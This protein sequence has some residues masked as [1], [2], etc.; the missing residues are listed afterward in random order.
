MSKMKS[1]RSIVIAGLCGLALALPAVRSAQSAEPVKVR[2]AMLYLVHSAQLMDPLFPQ[3]AK[4]YGLDVEVIRMQRYPE[5][6]T[7]LATGQVDFGALGFTNI[8]LMADQNYSN[9]KFVAGTSVG[10]QGLILNKGLNG[11]VRKW[12]D[13]NGLKIGSAPGGAADNIFRTLVRQHGVNLHIVNFPGMGPQALEALKRGDADGLVWWE[14]SEAHAVKAGFA[15]Y[16]A[17]KLEE[18]PTGN[19]NGALAVNTQFSG[20]HPQAVVDMLKTLVETTDYLKQNREEWTRLVSGKM[21]VPAEIVQE[22]MKHL[23][24][25]YEMPADKIA[26]L[27]EGMAQFKLIKHDHKDA[28]AKFVDYSYLEKA[29]GKTRKQLGG[30]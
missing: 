29:T 19:I 23:A 13:L 20:K 12:K 8:G 18:S 2:L 30:N 11:K 14:P 3:R 22:S 5:V 28:V 10:G 25:S 6:Q 24:I 4:K 15:E 1:R 7:A 27:L 21:G 9:V 16:S 26:A 17:L